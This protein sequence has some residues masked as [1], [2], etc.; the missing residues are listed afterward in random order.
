M[1]HVHRHAGSDLAL[2]TARRLADWWEQVAAGMDDD[3]HE[4]MLHT[5]FGVCADH[6]LS[7]TDLRDGPAVRGVSAGEAIVR[8]AMA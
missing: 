8:A 4:A 6:L 5:E 2:T 7:P 3:I 1:E